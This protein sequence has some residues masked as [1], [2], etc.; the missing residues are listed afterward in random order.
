VVETVGNSASR[1]TGATAPSG[2][3]RSTA[4]GAVA[5]L[6]GA[7]LWAVIVE[8]S[9]YEVGIAAVGIGFLVG[10]AMAATAGTSNR[11]PPIGAVLALLGCLLGNAFVDAHEVAKTVGTSTAHVLK[12][13]VS[14]L[15]LSAHIFKAGFEAID[16][17]F[18]AIAAYE[19]YK[20]TARAV[21]RV[22]QR[23]AVTGPTAT[24]A[25]T[26]SAAAYPW[27]SGTP[28]TPATTTPAPS[29]PEP[30]TSEPTTI[31]EPSTPDAG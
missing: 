29:T 22:R 25:F 19:G 18:W 13:M 21:T 23:P 17:V 20:L 10:L 11:L 9:G 1:G 31:P 27:Q 14:D 15:N 28:S 6:V 24:A 7:I 26:P 3:L 12:V 16:L 4:A 2:L 5:A 30:R 8:V